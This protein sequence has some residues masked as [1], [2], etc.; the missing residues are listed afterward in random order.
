MGQVLLHDMALDPGRV[1]YT[2]GSW[3]ETIPVRVELPVSDS[4]GQRDSHQR[5]PFAATRVACLSPHHPDLARQAALMFD[6]SFKC[7]HGNTD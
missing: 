7:S 3:P 4:R 1:V 2:G 5:A 6:M